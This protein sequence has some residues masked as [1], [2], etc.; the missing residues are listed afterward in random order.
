MSLLY[1]QP[2][3]KPITLSRLVD[4]IRIFPDGREVCET[5]EA[6]DRRRGECRTLAAGRCSCRRM[7]PL[8]DER[9]ENG[10]VVRYAGHA[11]HIVSRGMGGAKR[12][13]RLHNLR[14]S[15]FWCHNRRHQ[16]AKPCPK[17]VLA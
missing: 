5:K 4:G 16:G 3:P 10:D 11:D 17:K 1:F 7:V 12:D 9:N 14:W 6:W 15:C 13:D 2:H 8:H